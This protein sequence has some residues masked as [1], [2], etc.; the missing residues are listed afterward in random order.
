M[1]TTK[2][3]SKDEQAITNERSAASD[4]DSSVDHYRCPYCLAEPYTSPKEREVRTH[5]EL[6][7]DGEHGG[8][9]G[10]SPVTYV[11]AVDDCGEVVK[12]T[13]GKGVKRDPDEFA[14]ICDPDD[15]LTTTE[16]RIVATKMMHLDASAGDIV[17]FLDERC[18]APSKGY[19]Q[20]T[21]WDYFGT[22]DTAR[23][24]R[25]YE[26]LNERQQAAIDAFARYE[27]GEFETQVE[28]AQNIDERVDYVRRCS[29]DFE[30]VVEHRVNALDGDDSGGKGNSASDTDS[31]RR[32]NGT[33][34]YVGPE[35]GIDATMQ[36][37]SERPVN[38]E[39]EDDCDSPAEVENG[40]E[41]DRET[42][43][44]LAEVRGRV[45]TLRR[46][47]AD[48]KLDAEVAFDEVEQILANAVAV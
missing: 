23:R 19:V 34:T 5:I 36:H 30:G 41:D 32:E 14:E 8:R 45:D 42:D 21:L 47:V 40:S 44:E 27:L 12:E 4:G 48:D 46:L 18:E 28:A 16:R 3:D 2:D 13:D 31:V 38:G 1:A 33:G 22:T 39:V 29:Y 43:P 24:T 11:E 10:F 37:F 26:E 17:E 25:S 6:A 7:S 9:K 20:Q 35:G 15:D